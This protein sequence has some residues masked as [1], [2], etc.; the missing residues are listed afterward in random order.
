[1]LCPLAMLEAPKL[2]L[3]MLAA[4]ALEFEHGEPRLALLPWQLRWVLSTLRLRQKHRS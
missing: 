4:P 1:M 3:Q 2:L